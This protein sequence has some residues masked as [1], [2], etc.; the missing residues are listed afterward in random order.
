MASSEIVQCLTA[1]LS[2]ETSTRVT[3]ELKLS[4]LFTRPGALFT[5]HRWPEH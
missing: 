1:A 4:T 5:A 2:P 3:A